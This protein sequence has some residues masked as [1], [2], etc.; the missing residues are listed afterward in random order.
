M[1]KDP[2]TFNPERYLGPH[3]EP[4]FATL[5]FGMGR[6]ICPGMHLADASLFLYVASILATLNIGKP[7]D[8]NGVEYTP[9]L[10]FTSGVIRSVSSFWL[11]EAG[12]ML[13]SVV[14]SMPEPFQCTITPRNPA[15]AN[16]VRD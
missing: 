1:H 5:P 9:P 16:L 2:Y 12:L 13:K 3:P 6:R 14:H 8:A 10:K 4:D 11:F 15:V 7:K